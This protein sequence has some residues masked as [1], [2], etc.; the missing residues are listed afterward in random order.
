MFNRVFFFRENFSCSWLVYFSCYAS[1]CRMVVR[2]RVA[3]SERNRVTSSF[4]VS[5]LGPSRPATSFK[6]RCLRC[7]RVG[8]VRC[9]CLLMKR[10]E[11]PFVLLFNRRGHYHPEWIQISSLRSICIIFPSACL[12]S[13]IPSVIPLPTS[14]FAVSVLMMCAWLL[15]QKRTNEYVPDEC[16]WQHV[17]LASLFR[18]QVRSS[19][20]IQTCSH[21]VD[22]CW[23]YASPEC[24]LGDGFVT[25]C[26]A[27]K[28][29][30]HGQYN[31]DDDFIGQ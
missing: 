3:R 2:V 11:L 25:F 29:R 20:P 23:Q 4:L 14:S 7:T 27:T 6:C 17:I 16:L 26:C 18:W 19:Y 10:I 31:F 21:H 30:P 13:R 28:L 15:V 24:F 1:A 22:V 5:L 9:L 12:A 8:W